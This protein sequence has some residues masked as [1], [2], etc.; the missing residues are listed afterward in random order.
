[1]ERKACNKVATCQG[2]FKIPRTF[3]HGWSTSRTSNNFDDRSIVVKAG[4]TIVGFKISSRYPQTSNKDILDL[5]EKWS[6]S[7]WFPKVCP[8]SYKWE[9]ILPVEL[10]FG[11][12][13]QS[14]ELRH[15]TLVWT[16]RLI[17]KEKKAHIIISYVGYQLDIVA[18]TWHPLDVLGTTPEVV[19]TLIQKKPS[20]RST[21]WRCDFFDSFGVNAM[22]DGNWVLKSW[23]KVEFLISLMVPA[24]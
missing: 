21:C 9:R 19:Y 5:K 13:D 24:A 11:S 17:D 22:Q 8:V 4:Y 15:A 14:E 6:L 16:C 7:F 12:G 2:G 3:L 1:M 18:D 23:Q 10:N 20:W